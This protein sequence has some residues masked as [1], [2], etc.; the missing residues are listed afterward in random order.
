MQT[1]YGEVEGQPYV[2]GTG[3]KRGPLSPRA[4]KLRRVAGGL[5][6]GVVGC[7]RAG[8]QQHC[9]ERQVEV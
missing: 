1:E 4:Q 2:P 9:L 8:R 5:V 6:A 3:W 7:G